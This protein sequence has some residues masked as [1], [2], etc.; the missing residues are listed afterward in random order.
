VQVAANFG[1]RQVEFKVD[2]TF[3]TATILSI[4]EHNRFLKGSMR[5]SSAARANKTAFLRV[6]FSSNSNT[7]MNLE[8]YNQ[9]MNIKMQFKFLPDEHFEDVRLDA[10]DVDR[11]RHFASNQA[12]K[13]LAG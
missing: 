2:Q 10:F 8:I 9:F 1:T 3:S 4:L 12:F 11:T 7:E 6:K 5:N 13:K